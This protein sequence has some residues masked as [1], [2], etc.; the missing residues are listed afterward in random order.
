[1]SDL[2]REEM[3]AHRVAMQEAQAREEA[4]AGEGREAEADEEEVG[5]PLREAHDDESCEEAREAELQ[6]ALGSERA[7]AHQRQ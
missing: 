5:V 4:E 7:G 6:R 3:D 2:L 1:M